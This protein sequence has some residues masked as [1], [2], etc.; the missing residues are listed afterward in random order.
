MNVGRPSKLTPELI[1]AAKG[2]LP[3]CVDVPYLDQQGNETGKVKC[4]IPTIERFAIYLD[5][6]RES[7]TNW[8][9]EDSDLGREFLGILDS[10][11][12]EQSARLIEN[13][14]G[15]QYNPTIAKLILGKHGYV[16]EKHTDHTTDG[17][18]LPTPI[19]GN[20]T[21]PTHNGN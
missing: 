21:I 11:R 17:K 2:Y 15:G 19:L 5:C 14:L 4:K 20:D 9:N 8:S 12:K 18:A 13:G 3:T 1:E 6:A 7:I 16:D 10:V